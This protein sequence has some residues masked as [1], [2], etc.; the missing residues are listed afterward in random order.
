MLEPSSAAIDCHSAW[1]APAEQAF[2]RLPTSA[3]SPLQSSKQKV[4]VVVKLDKYGNEVDDDS[5]ATTNQY[6][7]YYYRRRRLRLR[8]REQA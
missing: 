1:R 7:H 6:Y 2:F 5:I 8:R 4:E 3:K